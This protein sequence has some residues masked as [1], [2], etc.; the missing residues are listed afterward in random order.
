MKK[1][2]LMTVAL[3][4]LLAAYGSVY[5]SVEAAGQTPAMR[6]AVAAPRPMAAPAV[7]N[8]PAASPP[9][10]VAPPPPP[11]L[12]ME[13]DVAFPFRRC[14]PLNGKD[15]QGSQIVPPRSSDFNLVP[16]FFLHYRF[17]NHLVLGGLLF[18]IRRLAVRRWSRVLI[19]IYFPIPV[20]AAIT[21]VIGRGVIR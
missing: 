13:V 15:Q 18:C 21:V 11:P 20:V 1:V 3:T 16:V 10:R 6:P 2:V 9:P 5:E 14:K 17:G 4:C 8:S 7:M 19:V 12:A